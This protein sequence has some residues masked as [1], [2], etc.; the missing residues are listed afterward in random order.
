MRDY[1]HI[2]HYLNQ[3]VTDV[4][5]QPPDDLHERFTQTVIEE[6]FPVNMNNATVLDVGC[7]Q[8]GAAKYFIQKNM[9]WTGVTLGSDYD[10]CKA[11]G[12]AVYQADFSFLPFPDN[13]FDIVFARH[14]LEHSPFPLLTLMEW[15]RV[16]KNYLCLVLPSP[17]HF[18][19]FGRNHYAV[20][21]NSQALWLTARAGWEP[22]M[23]D[24][25]EL[26]ELRYLFQKSVPRTETMW[27]AESNLEIEYNE[28]VQ[29][30]K[31]W[32]E[33]T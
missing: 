22:V 17:K 18:K 24:Y 21:T 25:D 32:N 16:A 27:E 26:Q 3:L 19:Y 15:H 31:D 11:K 33:E 4:Y 14:S 12:L 30:T 6:F 20:M 13:N 9:F 2:D 5:P 10:V 28:K 1:S 23:K 29:G 7:G 8:G